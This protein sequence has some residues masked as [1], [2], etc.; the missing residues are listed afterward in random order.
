MLRSGRHDNLGEQRNT[1]PRAHTDLS[2]R[3]KRSEVQGLGL[4]S[5]QLS[6]AFHIR[7]HQVK[8]DNPHNREHVIGDLFPGP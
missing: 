1:T 8:Q 7:H 4:L 3:A 5:A 2:S 6:L